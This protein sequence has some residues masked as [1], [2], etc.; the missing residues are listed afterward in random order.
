[1]NMIVKTILVASITMT[2]VLVV[3][4]GPRPSKKTARPTTTNKSISEEPTIVQVSSFKFEPKVLTVKPGT[5]VR[6]I[7][8]SGFH[9]VEADNGSFKS[10]EL[11][12]EN[13]Y[14]DHKFDK[15]GKFPYHCSFHGNKGGKDMAGTIIVQK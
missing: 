6:W 1:M 12:S 10:T 9:T 8:K 5:T 13:S 11:K 7:N 4:A 2:T 3:S 14:F 15:A